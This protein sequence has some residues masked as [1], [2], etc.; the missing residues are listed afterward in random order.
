MTRRTS[1][2]V[3]FKRPFILDGF[4]RIQPAGTYLVET[5]EEELGTVSVPAYRHM[6][7]MIELKRAGLT[8]YYPIDPGELDE[9]LLRDS[10]P[11]P[12]LSSVPMWTGTGPS[13][14]RRQ[15]A[16]RRNRLL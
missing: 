6:S 13:L 15:D 10:A 14:A 7:T 1:R 9:A 12:A 16:T 4:E 8:E 11:P 5:E 3:T 2:T